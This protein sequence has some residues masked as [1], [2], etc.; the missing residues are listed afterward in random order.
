MSVWF[1]RSYIDF[2]DLDVT[3]TP[4]GPYGYVE[5]GTNI[6][7]AN[8]LG[9]LCRAP[10]KDG[11]LGQRPLDSS[12]ISNFA[13]SVLAVASERKIT[14]HAFKA[15]TLAWASRYGLSEDA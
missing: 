3:E 14:S 5:S 7:D 15:T 2:L 12:E 9:A 13:C 1:D 6:V 10:L 4:E 11:S 8:P